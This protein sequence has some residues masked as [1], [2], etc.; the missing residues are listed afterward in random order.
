MN[1]SRSVFDEL[2]QLIHRLCGLVVDDDKAYLIR[3]RLGPV[4]RTAGCR[5]FEELA[6]KL[7]GPEGAAL[8]AS[9]V[10]AITTAETSFFRDGHPF[11]A[12]RC[13][14]LPRLGEKA[15]AGVK[16]RLWCAAASTGQE[17]YSLAM[18]LHDYLTANRGVGLRKSD[19]SILATDISERVLATARAAE[20][21][22]RDVARGLT[23]AVLAR[24]LEK[25]HGVWAVREPVRR[26][27]DF[28]RLNLTGPLIDLPAFDAIFCRNLLIYFDLDARRRICRNLHNLL[29]DGGW[30]VLGAAENLYGVSEQ[31]ESLRL[32]DAL[33]Y[34]KAAPDGRC[35]PET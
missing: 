22:D 2:R 24:H 9:I 4:A 20:Y 17:P 5:S 7:R 18:L 28:R 16:V 8:H 11:E 15:R 30:L 3:H 33:V 29:T 35:A 12:F 23:P 13:H 31:F 1:L 25:R 14:L 34:R 6:Q 26:L 27:V 19:F 32:G 10:E 21:G